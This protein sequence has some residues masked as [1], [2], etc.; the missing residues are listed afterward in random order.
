MIVTVI[1]FKILFYF[2]KIDKN[3]KKVY[4]WLSGAKDDYILNNSD[5]TDANSDF[6]IE[7]VESDESTNQKLFIL[8]FLYKK[9]KCKFLL[10]K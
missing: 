7:N 2:Y 9:F 4:M 3:S 8:N 5:D 1:I 10:N 6:C